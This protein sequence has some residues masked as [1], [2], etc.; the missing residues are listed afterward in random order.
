MQLKDSLKLHSNT[1]T[2][3]ELKTLCILIAKCEDEKDL[4]HIL[5]SH[6]LL[7]ESLWKPY[8]NDVFNYSII[9]NQQESAEVALVEKFVNCIDHLLILKCLE[10]GIDPRSDEAPSSM[11]EAVAKFLFGS[12]SGARKIPKG[13]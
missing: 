2:N 4:I 1:F 13:F 8:G 5:K 3:E 12:R 11:T 10:K 9:G 6:E 7:D